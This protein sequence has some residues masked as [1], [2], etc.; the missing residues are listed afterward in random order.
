MSMSKDVCVS[1]SRTIKT[2]HKLISCKLCKLYVHKKCTKMKPRELKNIDIINEW[3]C[4]NCSVN[5]NPN[6]VNHSNDIENLNKNVN[7]QASAIDK[8]DKMIFNPLRFENMSK[9]NN[10]CD[11]EDTNIDIDCTLC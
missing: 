1:C 6:T 11:S 10:E 4:Q 2:C 9:T 5:E 7:V 3:R 8:Y